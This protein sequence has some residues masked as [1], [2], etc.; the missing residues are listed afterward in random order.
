ML[1]DF[2]WPMYNPGTVNDSRREN[3]RIGAFNRISSYAS[4]FFL[5]PVLRCRVDIV[6]KDGAPKTLT[7]TFSFRTLSPLL[8][9]G[10]WLY[11]ALLMQSVSKNRGSGNHPSLHSNCHQSKSATSTLY[12]GAT[13]W[14]YADLFLPIL[15]QHP[16][17]LPMQSDPERCLIKPC[18]WVTRRDMQLWLYGE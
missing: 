1:W 3:D 6:A 5:V 8:A 17:R 2:L 11:F 7:L 4:V 14:T 12:L 13:T 18:L 9:L 15:C 10:A 16:D